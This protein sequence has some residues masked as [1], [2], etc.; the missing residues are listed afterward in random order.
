MKIEIIK[1]DGFGLLA[2]IRIGEQVLGVMDEF[3]MIELEYLEISEPE[4]SYLSLEGLS[5]ELMFGGNPNQE[6]KL[7][8]TGDWSYEAY[9]QII[10]INPVFADFGLF[11]LELGNFT[12]DDRCVGEWIVEKIDRLELT[13]KTTAE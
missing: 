6:K 12:N 5:W 2:E 10:S 13:F 8:R 3:S 1:T 11:T 7:V 9:G 4:F